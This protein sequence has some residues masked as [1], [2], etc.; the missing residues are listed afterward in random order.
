MARI[1]LLRGSNQGMRDQSHSFTVLGL[2]LAKRFLES[3]CLDKSPKSKKQYVSGSA[4]K[5]ANDRIVCRDKRGG[6]F[7]TSKSYE[8]VYVGKFVSRGELKDAFKVAAKRL[9]SA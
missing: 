5:N 9:K 8:R 4:L 6:T 1:R 2:R 3:P 7:V